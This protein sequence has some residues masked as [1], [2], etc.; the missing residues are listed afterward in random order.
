MDGDGIGSSR[1]NTSA[2][3]LTVSKRN[4]GLHGGERPHQ[5]PTETF[6]I[7]AH[8][9]VHPAFNQIKSLNLVLVSN[10]MSL[11]IQLLQPCQSLESYTI[12]RGPTS[13]IC[14]PMADFCTEI[15][16]LVTHWCGSG[17]DLPRS[18]GA[19]RIADR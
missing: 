18:E 12:Q 15:P 14:V 3:R 11:L 13:Y 16:V 7:E 19:R 9:P 6:L 10:F 1:K 8:L 17:C 5:G 4:I 2:C